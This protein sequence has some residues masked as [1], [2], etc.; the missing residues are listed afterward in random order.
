MQNKVV[1]YNVGT[2]HLT[3]ANAC[4]GCNPPQYQSFLSEEYKATVGNGFLRLRFTDWKYLGFGE[5]EEKETFRETTSYELSEKLWNLERE[6]DGLEEYY[7]EKKVTLMYHLDLVDET[8]PILVEIVKEIKEAK[9]ER[10]H[11][12]Q[13]KKELECIEEISLTE[14][15]IEMKNNSEDSLN[16]FEEF[17]LSVED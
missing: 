6:I 5:I 17:V 4:I 14:W 15:C 2:P 12:E 7:N 3:D 10:N 8:H 9:K 16:L 1:N 13:L 11:T